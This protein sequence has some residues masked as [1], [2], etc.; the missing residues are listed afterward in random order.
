MEYCPVLLQIGPQIRKEFYKG[1]DFA[2]LLQVWD[3]ENNKVFEKQLISK[4]SDSY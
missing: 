4:Q 2:Y 3:K 1:T